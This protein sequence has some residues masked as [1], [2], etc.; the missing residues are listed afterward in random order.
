MTN[1]SMWFIATRE[2][3]H[4]TK[5]NHTKHDDLSENLSH[6]TLLPV[7]FTVTSSRPIAKLV[8][9]I[10]QQSLSFAWEQ[11]SATRKLTFDNLNNS[12]VAAKW[13]PIESCATSISMHMIPIHAESP[14]NYLKFQVYFSQ[15]TSTSLSS[16]HHHQLRL[17][18]GSLSL[19]VN[20]SPQL[21]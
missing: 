10:C 1:E 16:Q 11:A 3:Y 13:R 14:E 7:F 2:I 19:D 5:K 18:I 4:H 6:F 9:L 8:K 21:D 12:I 20:R 17:L 15:A